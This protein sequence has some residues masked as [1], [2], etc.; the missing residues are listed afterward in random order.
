M[1]YS[2]EH[3]AAHCAADNASAASHILGRPGPG[4]PSGFLVV[5]GRAEGVARGRACVSCRIFSHSQPAL[6][7]LS[8]RSPLHLAPSAPLCAGAKHRITPGT[9][10]ALVLERRQGA[11]FV[12][13]AVVTGPLPGGERQLSDINS[14]PTLIVAKQQI[15][16]MGI[17]HATSRADGRMNTRMSSGEVA[18]DDEIVAFAAADDLKLIICGQAAQLVGTDGK[19]VTGCRL[20]LVAC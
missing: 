19:S 6:L 13:V 20:R 1:S 14:N 9:K 16:A 12:Q 18:L 3:C 11:A 7:T 5:P 17:S 15:E 4:E 2:A 10:V 8:L